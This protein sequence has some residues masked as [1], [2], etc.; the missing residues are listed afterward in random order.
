MAFNLAFDKAGNNIAARMAMMA[1][2]TSNSIRV[3]PWR[4][5]FLLAFILQFFH[6]VP[7]RPFNLGNRKTGRF[8]VTRGSIAFRHILGD[9]GS[10]L[11]QLIWVVFRFWTSVQY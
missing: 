11:P 6:L 8:H 2:T 3:K 9:Y 7:K 4:P 5:Q 10:T 1:M